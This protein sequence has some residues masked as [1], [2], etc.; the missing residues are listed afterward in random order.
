MTLFANFRCRSDNAKYAFT[1][2]KATGAGSKKIGTAPDYSRLVFSR[3]FTVIKVQR[4]IDLQAIP[5]LGF[6]PEQ[7]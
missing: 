6:L 1:P 7:Q 2:G 5:D 3:P 4:S